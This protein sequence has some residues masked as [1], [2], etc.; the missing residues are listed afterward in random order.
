[1]KR[2]FMQVRR[3][4]VTA[5]CFAAGNA[6]MSVLF[7]SVD[8]ANRRSGSDSTRAS[9]EGHA[10]GLYFLIMN[11][12]MSAI[13]FSV[14]AAL[15]PRWRHQDAAAAACWSV[16]AGVVGF[17]MQWVG[18]P[19]VVLPYLA[20]AI[21]FPAILITTLLPGIVAGVVVLVAST[22]IRPWRP[23]TRP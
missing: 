10:M 5:L 7:V 12:V 8:Y 22:I 13:V 14:V 3:C 19:L 6:L 18:L 11:G 4:L 21:G 2:A 23:T 15:A 17:M 16:A 9:L 20:R 1:M